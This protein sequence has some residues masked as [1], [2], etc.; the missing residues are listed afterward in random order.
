MRALSIEIGAT[1]LVALAYAQFPPTPAGMT[2]TT[3]KVNE[4][5]KISWKKV[6]KES[7]P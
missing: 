7:N 3:S 1:A 2:L 6:S 5:V 4:K